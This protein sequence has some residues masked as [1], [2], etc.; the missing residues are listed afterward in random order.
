MAVEKSRRAIYFDLSQDKL[1]VFYGKQNTNQAYFD[2]RKE[3]L[4]LGFEHRQGSGYCSKNA[5]SDSRLFRVMKTLCKRL[6][7]L[8]FCVN[9][10][11]ATTIGQTFDF[12][13][14]CYK[15]SQSLFKTNADIKFDD[16]EH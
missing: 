8:G 4:K 6:P 7:W 14:F 5:I 15:Q 3:M 11:D 13:D 9:K 2:I 16:L 12:K 10:I 1:A